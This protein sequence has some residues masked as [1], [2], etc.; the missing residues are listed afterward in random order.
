M[1]RSRGPD[2]RQGESTLTGEE[3]DRH[4]RGFDDWHLR[5][6]SDDV[7]QAEEKNAQKQ[8]CIDRKGLGQR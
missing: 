5:R 8:A 1:K 6:R 2:P 4:L 7:V 3:R